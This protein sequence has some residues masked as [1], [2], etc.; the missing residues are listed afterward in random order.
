MLRAEGITA[1]FGLAAPLDLACAGSLAILGPNG[2]GKSTLI[3]LLA[4]IDRPLTGRITLDGIDLATLDPR[5]RARAVALV[6]QA[7]TPPRGFTVEQVVAQGRFAHGGHD[8][9][10][11]VDDALARADLEPLRRRRVETLSGGEAQRVVL[12]R[13]IAQQ[14]RW[15]LLDEPFAH[16]DPA[17][18]VAMWGVIR[19]APA[20][21]VAVLHDLNQA[22]AFPAWAL[23][24]A[25]RLVAHGPSPD[26]ATAAQLEATF[27]IAMQVIEGP[28][29]PV[30]LPPRGDA[31]VSPGGE[32]TGEGSGR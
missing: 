11:A 23:L 22:L 9:D 27:G 19:R 30:V 18:R 17:Q 3:R 8:P 15:L 2:A 24:R 20:T 7:T 12:A 32:P 26:L 1:R 6:P 4:G 28:T 5:A 31:R 10:G 25:G 29:G 13:A 16:L 14:S 21:C